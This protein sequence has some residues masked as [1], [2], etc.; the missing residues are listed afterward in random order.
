MGGEPGVV[1]GGEREEAT[2][3]EKS[4]GGWVVAAG[5]VQISHEI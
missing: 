3:R 2:R 5:L 1:T 4:P